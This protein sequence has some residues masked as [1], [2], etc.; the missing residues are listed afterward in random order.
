MRRQR[1]Q[2]RR[3]AVEAMHVPHDTVLVGRDVERA[4]DG[5]LLVRRAALKRHRAADVA[6]RAPLAA[7]RL[8][9]PL[10]LLAGRSIPP[11]RALVAVRGWAS[12]RGGL[13]GA[14][15]FGVALRGW[16]G[17]GRRRDSIHLRRRLVWRRG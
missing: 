14:P 16:L 2:A 11:E 8:E 6:Q 7:T 10:G 12:A 13:S 9:R 15:S 1:M 5:G 3:V 4:L 17:H